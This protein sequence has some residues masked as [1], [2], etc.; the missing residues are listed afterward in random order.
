MQQL[1][2]FFLLS[3]EPPVGSS[4]SHFRNSAYQLPLTICHEW[5][6]RLESSSCQTSRPIS[7]CGSSMLRQWCCPRG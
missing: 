6:G 2:A 4:G 3:P 1:L 5:V 7:C